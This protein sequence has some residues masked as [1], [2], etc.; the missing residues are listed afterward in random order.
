MLGYLTP[1]LIDRASGGN[2]AVAGRAYAYNVA[3]CI[4]GPLAAG[5]LL[6]HELS[7]LYIAIMVAGCG[8]MVWASL[9]LERRLPA[10]A[11]GRTGVAVT[12]S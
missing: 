4:L 9:V 7:V 12:R 6:R 5:F 10:R 1:L 11:N 2:A 8:A 3:G